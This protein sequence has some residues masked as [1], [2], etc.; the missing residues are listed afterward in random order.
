MGGRFRPEKQGKTM[1]AKVEIY[2]RAFC[3]FCAAAKRL[4]DDKNI[5]YSEIDV[6]MDRKLR[7]TM[8]G[9]ADGRNTLPQIFIN[10]KG[11][12][13][14]DELHALDADGKLDELLAE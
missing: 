1:A 4:L 8:V 5:A 6:T 2:T 12:G 11:V 9:R 7:E 3:G 14:S 10:G 13:G